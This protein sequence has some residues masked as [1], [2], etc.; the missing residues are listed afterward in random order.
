MRIGLGLLAVPAA[1]AL[2]ANADEGSFE[3]TVAALTSG[4]EQAGKPGDRLR[5]AG[6]TLLMLGAKPI[7]GDDLGMRW[8][9]GAKQNPPYRNRAL[10][11]GYRSVSLARGD[12][13]HFEQVFL[14][15]QR[16]QVALVPFN[17]SEFR[18]AVSDDQGGMQCAVPTAMRCSWIPL[19]TTR[20]R[21]DVVNTG[22]MPGISY[23]VMQ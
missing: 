5:A 20:Y 10:G 18:L 17:Q 19:W 12:A 16:A 21:I 2:L 1:L 6:T 23:L 9:K 4:A 3:R 13:A 8:S 15:G 14:A 22:K 7:D 11:P